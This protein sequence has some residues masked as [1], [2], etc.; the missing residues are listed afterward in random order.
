MSN[1]LTADILHLLSPR[2]GINVIV[3]A[4][5][6]FRKDD[7][8]GPYIAS[9][10]SSTDSL[11]IIDAGQTPENITDEIIAL[12]PS[13]IIVIDAA[14]YEGKAG[15]IRRIEEGQIPETTLSTHQ[16]PL[17]VVM[18]IIKNETNAEVIYLGVQVVDVGFGEGLSPKVKGMADHLVRHIKKKFYSS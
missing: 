6:N 7:G 9:Q 10:L 4:G 1:L 15:E 14:D 18:S 8:V 5:N 17:N 13:Y 11:K 3:T 12:K 16:I 2:S